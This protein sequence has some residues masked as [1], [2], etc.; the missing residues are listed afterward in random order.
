MGGRIL[1]TFEEKT[2][3]ECFKMLYSAVKEIKSGIKSAEL[4]NK[5]P[6]DIIKTAKA[7]ASL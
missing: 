6:A 5:Y 7:I 4:K 1:D 3:K 2:R